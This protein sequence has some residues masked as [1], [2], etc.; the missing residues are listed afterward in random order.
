M[1]IA[2]QIQSRDRSLR[3]SKLSSLKRLW[4]PA[5]ARTL[6][7]YSGVFSVHL[8]PPMT[9]RTSQLWRLNTATKYVHGEELLGSWKPRGVSLVQDFNSMQERINRKNQV[10]F[11]RQILNLKKQ[12]VQQ[13]EQVKEAATD[14]QERQLA[15]LK[16]IVDLWQLRLGTDK[17]IVISQDPPVQMDVPITAQREELQSTAK[18]LAEVEFVN[19]P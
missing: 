7:K 14:E 10:A 15:L 18:L 8:K 3:T 16:K 6:T 19:Q 9:R 17:D 1:D 12:Q 11:T 4:Y 13:T 2:I 5:A